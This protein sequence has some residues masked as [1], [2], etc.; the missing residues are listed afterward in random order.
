MLEILSAEA[1]LE[2]IERTGCLLHGMKALDHSA[3][4][5]LF[6]CHGMLTG[7]SSRRTSWYRASTRR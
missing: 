1:L 2:I 3:G 7:R 4:E 6:G 5:G